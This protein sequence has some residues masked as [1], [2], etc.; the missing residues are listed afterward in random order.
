MVNK[1]KGYTNNSW[2]IVTRGRSLLC[3]QNSSILQN[4][5]YHSISIYS[6]SYLFIIMFHIIIIYSNITVLQTGRKQQ[7]QLCIRTLTLSSW[8]RLKPR[9]NRCAGM[10]PLTEHDITWNFKNIEPSFFFPLFSLHPLS[11][12]GGPAAPS[13]CCLLLLPRLCETHQ[14]AFPTA[15]LTEP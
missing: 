11:Q 7:K 2:Q 6:I 9:A 13:V 14:A 1:F 3:T 10:N 5:I 8:N 12:A 4:R 15:A